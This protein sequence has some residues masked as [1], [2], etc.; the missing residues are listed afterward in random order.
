[1]FKRIQSLCLNLAVFLLFC[2]GAVVGGQEAHAAGGGIPVLGKTADG[3][4]PV[5][6]LQGD[7]DD[8]SYYSGNTQWQPDDLFK[9]NRM[10]YVD[11][12]DVQR[13]LAQCEIICKNRQQQ[14][15]GLNPARKWMSK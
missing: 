4:Y 13:G 1:M 14:V 3:K 5:Y 9:K 8:L 6:N 15:I 11:P 10:S 2:A 7:L 12:A